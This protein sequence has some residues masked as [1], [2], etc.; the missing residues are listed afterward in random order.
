MQEMGWANMG[1]QGRCAGLGRQRPRGRST[2]VT[3]APAKEALG[4][5]DS[6]PFMADDVEARAAVPETPVAKK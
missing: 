6:W 2:A 3:G 1:C 4:D 5:D